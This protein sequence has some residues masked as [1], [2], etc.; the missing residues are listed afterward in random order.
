MRQAHVSDQEVQS[1]NFEN[2]LP[3][4]TDEE[5]SNQVIPRSGI[6]RSPTLF[7]S[8][9]AISRTPEPEGDAGKGGGDGRHFDC[10]SGSINQSRTGRSSSLTAGAIASDAS[11]LDQ[12]QRG[13]SKSAGRLN[14]TTFVM[15]K[16]NGTK[17]KRKDVGRRLTMPSLLCVSANRSPFSPPSP[18]FVSRSACEPLRETE[19]FQFPKS[20]TDLKTVLLVSEDDVDKRDAFHEGLFLPRSPRPLEHKR[21][22]NLKTAVSPES[23]IL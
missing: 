5:P 1:F 8:G 11:R 6:P 4:P 2:I 3:T 9:V 18:H 12:L 23:S 19:V 7:I 17:S 22:R 20:P 13:L 10:D 14:R 21:K 15:N 16:P